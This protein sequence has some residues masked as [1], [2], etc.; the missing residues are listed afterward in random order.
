MSSDE[1]DLTSRR[2]FIKTAGTTVAAS[3]LAGLDIPAVH[4]AGSGLIQVAF[5]GCGGRGSGA[6]VQALSTKSGPI[7]L[8]AMA[9]SFEDRLTSSYNGLSKDA[10]IGKLVDVP[11][12]RRFVGYDGYKKAM[13]CLKPG[14]VVILTTPCAFRWPHFTYAIS[15][16]LNV[17]ME[18]PVTPDGPSARRMLLLAEQSV[19]KNLKVGV[20]LMSR[21][22]KPL[23]ELHDRVQNGEIGDIILMRGYRM[24]GLI[25]HFAS[26]PKPDNISHLDYQVRRFHSFLWSGGGAFSDYLIHHI[27]HLCWMKNAWPVK[28]Q[29]LGGRHYKNAPDGAPYVDQNFDSYAVEYTF[30]DGTK[31][32]M[33]GR[34]M[35]GAANFYASYLHGSKGSAVAARHGDFG[36]PAGTYH[37]Q[38]PDPA[39]TIWTSANGNDPYQ[40]EWDL[41]IAAIRNN[42]PYNEAKRGVEASV[43]TCMGRMA[44]HTGRQITFEDMLNCN[45]EMA[46][47]VETLTKDSP[48]PV[49]PGPD[50]RYPGPQPGVKTERE[51]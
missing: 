45:H 16:G 21:H 23:E 47:N 42:T 41:L 9:D 32:L 10:G 12:D 3:A 50:G 46:P 11:P 4:A 26:T 13:D 15:K 22:F 25:G 5:V 14:D 17:F 36:P 34:C 8:V 7:K 44:A 1:N 43:T 39:K 40:T 20:G 38:N 48:A 18:K 31:F 29:A 30:A 51:Y 49:M 24:Q 28:A 37:G 2:Q 33:D 27:D 19:A 6:A 35:E